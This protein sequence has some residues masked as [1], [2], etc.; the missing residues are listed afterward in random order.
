ML[1]MSLL[2]ILKIGYFARSSIHNITV[3]Y[4]VEQEQVNFCI[5]LAI[6]YQLRATKVTTNDFQ[7]KKKVWREEHAFFQKEHHQIW[8]VIGI[9]SWSRKNIFLVLCVI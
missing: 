5:S 9:D 2:K 1:H 6:P 7:K 4:K 8:F 3:I